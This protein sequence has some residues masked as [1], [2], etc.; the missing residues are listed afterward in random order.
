[1]CQEVTVMP[2]TRLNFH[3]LQK[4]KDGD[5]PQDPEGICAQ[6]CLCKTCFL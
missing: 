6:Q 4:L 5:F 3:H 2:H 1:M